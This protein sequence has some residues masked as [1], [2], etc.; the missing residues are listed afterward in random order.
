MAP[1]IDKLIAARRAKP[2]LPLWGRF[3]VNVDMRAGLTGCWIWR[4][5]LSTNHR[6]KKGARGTIQEAGRGSRLLK[7]HRLALCFAGAGLEEY[8]RPEVAAHRCGNPLCCNSYSH[9]YWATPA[10]NVA[11]RIE[12]ELRTVCPLYISAQRLKWYLQPEMWE[13]QAFIAELERIGR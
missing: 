6:R 7:A 9:L 3:W 2:L 11:D 4:G 12:H 13:H 1:N 5:T 8:D 10:E